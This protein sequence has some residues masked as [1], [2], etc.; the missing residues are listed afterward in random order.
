M[1][2]DEIDR[3]HRLGLLLTSGHAL[4]SYASV[5]E[6]F[7]VA[8]AFARKTLYQWRHISIDGMPVPGS[9]GAATT[10]DAS[11]NDKHEYDTVFVFAGQDPF[12]FNDRATFAWLRALARSQVRIA[13]VSGGSVLLAKAGLLDDYRATVHWEHRTMFMDLFPKVVLEDGL[14]VVDRRRMSCAGGIA[15]LDFAIDLVE[16]DYGG[17]LANTISDW[18]IRTDP[19]RA[20][21]PQ[22][23]GLRDRYGVLN[24]RVVRVLAE[25]EAHVEEP[26]SRKHLA[27]TSGISLRQL[28]RLFQQSMSQSIDRA[29]LAIRLEQAFQLLA[30]TGMP[31][32]AVSVAC[33]FCNSSHFAKAFRE[34]FQLSPTRFRQSRMI[35]DA[36]R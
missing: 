2:I 5:L 35:P 33:G 31:V 16:R 4:M 19:R 20:D 29:Y 25:M 14:F 1:N 18:F 13:G 8:N 6:P 23:M 15:G 24:D 26:R 10:T 36:G 22:R 12:A 28:E 21:H 27:R 34:R 9:H 11:I 3:P 7:R 30:G 17:T 32:A